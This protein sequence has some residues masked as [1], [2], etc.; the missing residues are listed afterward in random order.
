MKFKLAAVILSLLLLLGCTPMPGNET[1]PTASTAGTTPSAPSDEPTLPQT[2]A[3]A[4]S[5]Q[6]G[7]SLLSVLFINVGRAD[8]ALIQTD[9][10]S[11]LID[12][13]EKQSITALYRALAVRGVTKLDGVFLT[14]THADHIGGMDA[15]V[16]KYSVEKLYSAKISMNN[17]N[18][19]NKIDKLAAKLSLPQ[20]KLSTGDKVE[21][22]A[23]VY[24]EVLGPLVYNADDDNDNSLVMKLH[25]GDVT[26]LFTGD[27]QF[28]EENTLLGSKIDLTA[29]VLKV[30]NHGNPDASSEAFIEAVGAK[31]AVISTNTAADSDTPAPRV[32]SALSKAD[33]HVTQDYT[34]GVLL[35][36]GN[37]GRINISDSQPPAPVANIAI[38]S[39][40]K[41]AQTITL[42]NNGSDADLSDYYII[43]EK[44]NEIFVFP[45]GAALKSGQ[46]LTV[47]CMGGKGDYIWN[48]NKVWSKKGDE[49]GVLYDMYGNALS[50]AS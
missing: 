40:D 21:I 41:D 6:N 19:E 29:D 5:Q 31:T 47:A 15:L 8:A 42:I 18:G 39:I 36:I 9:G 49:A 4:P 30:A 10:K 33:V 13:G 24:F 27:M 16:Q 43:S 38:Q 7:D 20:T 1:V 37:D 35:T 45:E 2:A 46:A 28:A 48:D 22:T 50:R 11:Y 34:C 3:P 44:G 17:N 26:L 12:T 25:A 32:L 23:D 14:H